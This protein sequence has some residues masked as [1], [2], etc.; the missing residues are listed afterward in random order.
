MKT[1]FKIN[2]PAQGVLASLAT[3]CTCP[4]TGLTGSFLFTGESHRNPGSRV[5]EVYPGLAELF[6]AI[7]RDWETIGGGFDCRYRFM[8]CSESH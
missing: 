5:S 3:Q 4:D 7:K 8:G 2:K 6:P 1:I